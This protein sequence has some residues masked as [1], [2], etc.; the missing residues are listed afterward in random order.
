MT[1]LPT[2]IWTIF[3]Q[4]W[5]QVLT[6]A[7]RYLIE[8]EKISES[9]VDLE[10]LVRT[11]SW[12]TIGGVW[13]SLRRCPWLTR[14]P[15]Q[16]SD[17]GCGSSWKEMIWL[18]FQGTCHRTFAYIRLYLNITWEGGWGVLRNIE[19]FPWV[20]RFFSWVWVIFLE[21]FLNESSV[22]H[23]FLFLVGLCCEP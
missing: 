21:I 11:R 18:I 9:W 10:S 2:H 7:V 15:R 20:L 13:R 8:S 23:I 12:R 3:W 6:P 19:F 4:P 1:T 5:H 16:P 22:E 17:R 14:P